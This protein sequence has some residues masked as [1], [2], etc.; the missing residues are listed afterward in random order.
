MNKS[1]QIAVIIYFIIFLVIGINIYD[2]YGVPWDEGIQNKAA[3]INVFYINELTGYK[4]FSREKVSN[5]IQQT[6][7]AEKILSLEKS[8]DKNYG[9]INEL[10]LLTPTFILQTFNNPRKVLLTRHFMTFLIF[11]VSAIYFYL[12]IFMLY[13]NRI[14]SLFG[15]TALILSPRIFAE[16]F[17]NSKDLI[18]LSFFVI[19]VYYSIKFFENKKL[20]WAFAAGFTCALAIDIRIVATIIPVSV[21]FIF[22]FNLIIQRKNIPLKPE[23]IRLSTFLLVTL[24]SI[25]LFWPYLWANPFG[26]FF[27]SWMVMSKFGHHPNLLYMGEIINAGNLPWHYPIVWI[28]ITTPIIYSCLV[29]AGVIKFLYNSKSKIFT[30][31]HDSNYASKLLFFTISIGSLVAIIVL[32]STLYNGWRQIYFIYPF[33]LLSGFDFCFCLFQVLSKKK[34][35]KKIYVASILFVFL[36]VTKDIFS[37]HPHQ[38]IYFNRVVNKNIENNF[39]KDY[40]G[41]SLRDGLDWLMKNAKT[42]IIIYNEPF[43]PVKGSSRIFD[44]QQKQK[45]IFENDFNK[46]KYLLTNEVLLLYNTKN[47]MKYYNMSD[48]QLLYSKYING[49]KIY[50]IYK[51]NS[52]NR[53]LQNPKFKFVTN[54]RDF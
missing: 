18:L 51:L 28:L 10:I 22:I 41:L 36:I 47:M 17:Y 1:S 23:L 33:L 5:I 6:N 12:I 2:D 53:I 20:I 7:K 30:I 54:K 15:V 50:S 26:R 40:W 27:E 34:I 19:A 16:A 25:Y 14:A 52:N 31:G 29:I 39:E 48:A 11:W 9:V 45:L 38:M 43:N 21:I 13:K 4:I 42:P 8:D 32:H 24:V 44:E 3:L 49:L 35:L 37:M 46:S